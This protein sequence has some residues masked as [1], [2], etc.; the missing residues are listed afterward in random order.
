M[1]MTVKNDQLV[2][3]LLSMGALF[4]VYVEFEEDKS[5]LVDS[6]GHQH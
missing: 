2:S 4:E 6:N 5:L 1:M 3:G